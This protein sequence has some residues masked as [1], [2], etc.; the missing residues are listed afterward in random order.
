MRAMEPRITA[1]R[2]ELESHLGSTLESALQQ[3]ATSA[4]LHCLHAYVELGEAAPAER[5]LRRVVVSP[6]V[7][8]LVS[9]HKQQHTKGG[10]V[11]RAWGNGVGRG[12][13]ER[14]GAA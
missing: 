4:V 8:R 10:E 5:A 3:Q 12:T 13:G 2:T 7:A 11:G 6:L 14:P 1:Y 9:E